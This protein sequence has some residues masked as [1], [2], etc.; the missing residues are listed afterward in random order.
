MKSKRYFVP[1]PESIHTY[2][3]GR[4]VCQDNA[5]GK[6]EYKARTTE[7][8]LRQDGICPITGKWVDQNRAQF[9]HEAGRGS[10]GGHRDDRTRNDKGE[11][12]NAAVSHEGNTIKG[13]QRYHWLDGKY[14]PVSKSQDVLKLGSTEKQSRDGIAH[15]LHG[16][17]NGRSIWSHRGT[18]FSGQ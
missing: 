1:E 11:W 7:M 6:R 15:V 5:A 4:Q 13:S 9:D 3:D 10:N 8:W 18:K 12:Q 16:M 14:V 2:P 17:P